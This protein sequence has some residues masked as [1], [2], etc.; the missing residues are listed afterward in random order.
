[1]A[2]AP[3][4]FESDRFDLASFRGSQAYQRHR[5]YQVCLVFLRDH[6][7]QEDLKNQF[8]V[9]AGCKKCF[10]FSDFSIFDSSFDFVCSLLF[11]IFCTLS[12]Y[13]FISLSLKLT[14]NAAAGTLAFERCSSDFLSVRPGSMP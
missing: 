6:E 4:E 2:V 1:M 8:I 12:I 14:R 10:L 5:G 3:A 7:H 11:S 9:S 13:F